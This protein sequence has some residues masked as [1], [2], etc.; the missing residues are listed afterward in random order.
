L[1]QLVEAGLLDQLSDVLFQVTYEGYLAGDEI[2]V[3]R[4]QI[5][6]NP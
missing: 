2:M 5:L 6:T 3:S 4:G 1:D